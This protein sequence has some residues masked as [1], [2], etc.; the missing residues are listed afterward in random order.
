ML[1]RI[2][3][4][5]KNYFHLSLT[6]QFSPLLIRLFVYHDVNDGNDDDDDDDDDDDVLT[7]VS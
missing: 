2:P 4:I 1:S 3:Q 6:T 5:G 7:V